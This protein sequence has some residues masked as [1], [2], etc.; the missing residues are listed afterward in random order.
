M[1]RSLFYSLY[2]NTKKDS[3]NKPMHESRIIKF[4]NEK[5]SFEV[6]FLRSIYAHISDTCQGFSEKMHFCPIIPFLRGKD[7]PKY[8][9]GGFRECAK[10]YT[11]LPHPYIVGNCAAVGIHVTRIP[12]SR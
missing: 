4:L 5:S 12:S 11:Q 1:S 9:R 6:C 8:G 10:K 3:Q 2:I 7:I